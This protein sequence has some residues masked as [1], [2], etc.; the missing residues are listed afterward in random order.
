MIIL[1]VAYSTLRKPPIK[2]VQSIIKIKTTSQISDDL[3]TPEIIQRETT[4]TI[5]QGN[6]SKR[7]RPNN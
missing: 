5:D 4:V 3:K 6:K 1:F 2:N 7:D